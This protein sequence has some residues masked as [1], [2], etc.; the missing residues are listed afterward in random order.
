[1]TE[2]KH[3]PGP[4][5]VRSKTTVHMGDTQIARMTGDDWDGDR[6]VAE[7]QT[8]PRTHAE[9]WANSRLIAASPTLL[10]ALKAADELLRGIDPMDSPGGSQRL[11]DTIKAVRA[12]IEQAQ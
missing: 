11:A 3:T 5:L 8:K 12:A 1:M 7:K 6:I 10:D 9:Q 2:W 4:W